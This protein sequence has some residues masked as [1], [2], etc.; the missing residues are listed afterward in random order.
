MLASQG[1]ASLGP[2]VNATLAGQNIKVAMRLAAIVTI[3]LVLTSSVTFAGQSEAAQT[4]SKNDYETLLERVKDGEDEIDFAALR[5]AFAESDEYSPFGNESPDQ[6]ESV[7]KALEKGKHNKAVKLVQQLLDDFYLSG[8]AHY[9]A[10]VAL[11]KLGKS[12]EASFHLAVTRGLFDSICE[13]TDGTSPESPCRVISVDEEYFYLGASGLQVQEQTL[14][15]CKYGPCDMM[16]VRDQETDAES[17]LY[18]DIS[19]KMTAM[20]QLLDKD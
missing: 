4:P 5:F 14:S 6:L 19:T 16:R 13:D 10:S 15:T 9:A 20:S 1:R 2:Q 7:F 17:T 3:T 8:D 12:K 18:F 11:E